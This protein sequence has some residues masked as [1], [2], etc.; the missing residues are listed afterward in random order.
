[1]KCFEL[2]DYFLC[3]RMAAALKSIVSKKKLRY[4]QD[5]FNLDLSYINQ[6]IIAMGFPADSIESLYRLDII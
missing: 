5:G 2:R 6:R 3:S 1:M 4:V